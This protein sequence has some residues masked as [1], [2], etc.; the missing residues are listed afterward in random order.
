MIIQPI[1]FNKNLLGA[2]EHEFYFSIYVLGM[3]PFQLTDELIFF[4]GAGIPPTDPI[5]L[6]QG[7]LTPMSYDRNVY[8]IYIYILGIYQF[9]IYI[10]IYTFF[11]YNIIAIYIIYIYII[12]CI[13]IY[14][15]ISYYVYI[16]IY[17]L[18]YHVTI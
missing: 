10:Y 18:Y 9:N 2:L 17:E 13:Y 4:R 14:I 15:Y 5:D 11:F 16:Y 8:N 12:L 6:M 7:F 1:N 3:S